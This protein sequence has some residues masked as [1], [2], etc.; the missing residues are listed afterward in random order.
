MNKKE[1][2]EAIVIVLQ[3]AKRIPNYLKRFG[4]LNGAGLFFHLE[5]SGKEDRTSRKHIR[6]PGIPE[7]VVLRSTIADRSAFWICMVAEQYSIDRFP[8]HA[9][10]V[11]K[12]YNDLVRRGEKP[13]I[14][15]AGANIG[16][17]ALWYA[18]KFPQA[19][20]F[21]IEPE[22][23]NYEM[24]VENTRAFHDRVIPFHGG[25]WP[26]KTQLNIVN[27]DAG[28]QHFQLDASDDS[29]AGLD[30]V[31]V[32][33]ILQR[34]EADDILIA[35]IDIEG[36]QKALFSENTRWVERVS[37]IVLELD[38]WLFPWAGTSRPFFSCV[39]EYPFDYLLDGENVFAFQDV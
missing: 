28:A 14:I 13:L 22:I 30:S 26:Q 33:E 19:T 29:V 37:L 38:D 15:D 18:L 9:H 17:A 32:D 12:K 23:S 20:I 35:K 34:S 3:A 25:I 36:S 4:A 11:Y 6:V 16:M 2:R 31:T 7:P 39:S 24:L 21:A 10:R 27:K 5:S 1:N 8:I